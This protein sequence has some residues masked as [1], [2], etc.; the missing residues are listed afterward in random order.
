MTMVKGERN[1]RK[2]HDLELAECSRLESG[3][4]LVLKGSWTYM[5]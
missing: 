1:A 4:L 5:N 3:R 2:H